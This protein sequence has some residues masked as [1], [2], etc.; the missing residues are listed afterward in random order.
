MELLLK[1]YEKKANFN[2][3]CTLKA[4]LT[5]KEQENRQNTGKHRNQDHPT[6]EIEVL[7]L[8][9][10]M[11]THTEKLLKHLLWGRQGCSAGRR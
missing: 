2:L 10:D 6:T 11:S 3:L 8:N 4:D 9:G 5:V 7:N 1:I